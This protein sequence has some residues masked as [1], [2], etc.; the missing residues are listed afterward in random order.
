MTANLQ[1]L[2][3]L[4]VIDASRVLAGP[5]CAQILGDQGADVIKIESPDG[6]ESRTFGPPVTE[7][8]AAYF[9]A[10][11]RNKRGIVLDMSKSQ[12]RDVFWQ[13]LANADVLIE[14]F[15]ASTLRSWGIES[16]AAII[17]RFPRLVH[18][19]ITGFGDDGPLGGAPGYD[20]AIQ[21]VSGL[22]SINGEPEGEP[23]RLGL[24]VVDLSTGMQAAIAVLSALHERTRSGLGQMCDVALYDCAISIAHPYVPNY[25]WSGKEPART[26]NGHSNIAPYDAF[27]TATC[28]LYIAVGNDRQFATLC[29]VLGQ[30]ELARDPRFV[31]NAQRVAQRTLLNAKISELLGTQDGH[32]LADR[33][34]SAGVPAA[35][36]LSIA[37]VTKAPQALHRHMVIDKPDYHGSGFPIKFSRTP[38]TLH[39][40]P[41][42]C[43]EHT[44]AV[45]AEAGLDA[46]HIDALQANGALGRAA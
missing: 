3:G 25:L 14:N 38:S 12:A 46:Q 27:K 15:K 31:G 21:A 1:C 34:Q 19:R 32:A 4:R 33:L 13:L 30:P 6:D 7:G 44:R 26:G 35:P 24:P 28:G 40:L 10:L 16:P 37:Q 11:N 43:G 17:A 36:I 5:Y 45:L 8:G 42:Q 9:Q 29:K 22:M 20:A 39:R 2:T 41:P 23:L 18:C